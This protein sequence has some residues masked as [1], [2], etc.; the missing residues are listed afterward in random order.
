MTT[1]IDTPR[2]APGP[3]VGHHTDPAE[4]VR[5]MDMLDNPDTVKIAMVDLEIWGDPV[6]MGMET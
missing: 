3:A 2:N 1:E 6:L 5:G 4:V